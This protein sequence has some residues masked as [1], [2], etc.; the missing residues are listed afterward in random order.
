LHPEDKTKML[1]VQEITGPA[2]ARSLWKMPT[3]LL[4]PGED[5]DQAAMRE[6]KEE[7]GLQALRC[8]GVLCFRQAHGTSAGRA[9]SD[10]FFVCLLSVPLVDDL[11]PC[12]HEI[13]AIQWMPVQEY[14]DQEV[15]QMSPVYKELN[16]AVLDHVDNQQQGKPTSLVASQQLSVGFT[17]DTNT[18]Y[19]SYL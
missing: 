11:Q 14:A 18:V 12:Q 3:G 16:Q 2:A 6:L 1:V 13:K 9:T 17:P 19:R 10:L 7:T 8:E 4:D 5:I 15:W